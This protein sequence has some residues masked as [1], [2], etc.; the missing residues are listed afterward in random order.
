[1]TDQTAPQ[2]I[3]LN[4]PITDIAWSRAFYAALGFGFDD[5]FCDETSACVKISDTIYLMIMEH[6]K[7]AGFSPRPVSDPAQSAQHL[8]SLSRAGREE[9]DAIVAAAVGAGG[10]DNDRKMEMGDFMYGRSFSDPD[11]HV[12]EPM[13]MDV[14]KAMA[15][16][17]VT[18]PAPA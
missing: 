6:E 14:D 4:L 13:W 15:A 10:T 1:M 5:R 9:V 8:I 2:M 18:E 17:G 12:F 3:F 16:W 11:G 7:F